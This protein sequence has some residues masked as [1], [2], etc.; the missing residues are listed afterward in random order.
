MNTVLTAPHSD[1][2]FYRKRQAMLIFPLIV[3]PFIAVLF[4][5]FGGGRGERYQ[6]DEVAVG[7]ARFTGF[8][9]KVPN[10][11]NGSINGR[12][13]DG[14]GYGKAPIGQMLSNFTNTRQDSIS[15]GLKAIPVSHSVNANPTAH[16]SSLA[17]VPAMSSPAAR[18]ERPSNAAALAAT[19]ST[20]GKDYTY[21][22]PVRKSF[23]TQ[24]NTHQQPVSVQQ[25]VETG[26]PIPAVTSR[27]ATG[28]PAVATSEPNPASVRISDNLTASR[29]SEAGDE[30]SPFLTA[31][32]GGSRTQPTR[33]VLSGGNYG[34]KKVIVWMIPVVV[35]EDQ[36]IHDGQQVKL[37]LLKEVTAD[38]VTIPTNTI[39]YAICQL[40]DDRLRLTVR[41]L[42]LGGQLIPL[43]LDVYD[44]DGSP[45]INVPGL[46]NSS[47][48]G[49]QIRQSAIQGVQVPGVGSLA[50]N[51][52]N[53]A[54]MG[55]SNSVRQSTIRLKAGYNLFLKAQ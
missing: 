30:E 21:N 24:S 22:A 12:E 39:L 29:L 5:L 50:N 46:S 38:G 1:A 52:L 28:Q 47:Q 55:A 19:R 37:R 48:V 36:A 49:G 35:H 2:A 45:G 7:H 15:R 43:D 33:A 41:S 8:N 44:T 9:A 20:G 26:R 13:V 51:V 18:P 42:Q 10:A 17:S 54:R 32:T 31:P 6:V 25:T 4:W 34:Q 23:Y 16:A 27:V 11:K 53:S 3:L 40:S 14:P